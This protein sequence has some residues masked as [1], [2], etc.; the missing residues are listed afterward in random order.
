MIAF[1]LKISHFFTHSFKIYLAYV[2][3]C[4]EIITMRTYLILALCL[5]SSNLLADVN[6]TAA[7]EAIILN[8]ELQFLEDSV[9]NIQSASL[10]NSDAAKRDRA[11]NESKIENTYFGDDLEED[12]VNTK[13]STQKRR[14]L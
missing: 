2:G 9:G 11:L 1:E 4:Q 3:C 7:E 6:R 12:R 13:A 5:V 10:N 14:G 8:Q